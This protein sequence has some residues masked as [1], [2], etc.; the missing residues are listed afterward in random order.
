MDGAEESTFSS[1]SVA[2]S[3]EL[4]GA[5]VPG[6]QNCM[7]DV[8]PNLQPRNGKRAS[9]DAPARGPSAPGGRMGRV[10]DCQCLNL[11]SDTHHPSLLISSSPLSSPWLSEKVCIT[12]KFLVL[13]E[14][15]VLSVLNKYFPPDFDPS[16]IPRRKVPKNSQQV[17]RLMAPFSMYVPEVA[18]SLSA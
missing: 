4:P 18:S 16:L 3:S 10:V 17:V 15:I 5:T 8:C 7:L 2:L 9:F 13:E 14:L 6:F 1:V 12:V 11:Y